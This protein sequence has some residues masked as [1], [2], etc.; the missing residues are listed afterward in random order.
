MLTA[1]PV[2]THIATV[3]D[4]SSPDGSRDEHVSEYNCSNCFHSFI[5][6]LPTHD[7]GAPIHQNT[8]DAPYEEWCSNYRAFTLNTG[9]GYTSRVK[10]RGILNNRRRR[11]ASIED[12]KSKTQSV[13]S[14][15][16]CELTEIDLELKKESDA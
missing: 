16:T 7:S 4:F 9:S 2:S 8:Y 15:A 12:I 10:G 5:I 11:T 3:I 13:T 1:H 6:T 14:T